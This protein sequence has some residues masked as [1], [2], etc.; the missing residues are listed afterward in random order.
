MRPLRT[1]VDQTGLPPLSENPVLDRAAALKAADMMQKNYFAHT[2]P[3]GTDPWHWFKVSGYNYRFAGENLAIGYVDSQEVNQAWLD[4]PTHR[5]NI[6]NRNYKEI[7]IAVLQGSFQGAKTTV[8][9]QEFGTKQP[10]LFGKVF[11]SPAAAP[12]PATGAKQGSET[13]AK[14]SPGNVMG[15]S[16]INAALPLANNRPVVTDFL[17]LIMRRTYNRT[18]TSLYLYYI[19]YIRIVKTLTFQH[20]RRRTWL[21]HS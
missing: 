5:A 13:A 20:K 18:S 12:L 14:P 9:V 17:S 3:D 4:S 15:A 10:A 6:L 1:H 8:V 21:L 19:R 7:G 2:S 16:D 11:A